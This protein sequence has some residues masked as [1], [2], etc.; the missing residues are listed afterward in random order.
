M[1]KAIVDWAYVGNGTP[2]G[3]ALVQGIEWL[4]T[5]PYSISWLVTSTTCLAADIGTTP[6]RHATQV[7]SVHL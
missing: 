6:L 4:L 7:D 3:Q 2:N 5:R 1:F